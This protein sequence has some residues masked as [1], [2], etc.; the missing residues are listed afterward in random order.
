MLKLSNCLKMSSRSSRLEA[1]FGT[2]QPRHR[3][4]L[5]PS[6]QF[7]FE[8]SSLLASGMLSPYSLSRMA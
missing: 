1:L 4:I 7:T 5:L 6:Y 3:C 8:E 2:S